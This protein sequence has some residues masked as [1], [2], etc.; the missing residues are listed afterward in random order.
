MKRTMSRIALV[1][2][3]GATVAATHGGTSRA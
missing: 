1:A 3:A 2:V